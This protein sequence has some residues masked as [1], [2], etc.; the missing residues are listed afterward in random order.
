MEQSPRF[1]LSAIDWQ[2]LRMGAMVSGAGLILTAI[3]M[4]A[5]YSY[6]IAGHDVTV[7]VMFVL[8][9]LANLLRK[10]VSDHTQ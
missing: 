6:Q 2:K 3:P 9:N 4:F 7:I 5:G 1:S 10:Y 8:S